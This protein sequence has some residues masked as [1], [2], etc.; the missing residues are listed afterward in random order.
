MFVYGANGE[1]DGPA[2]LTNKEF[3]KK[4]ANQYTALLSSYTAEGQ[5]YRVD[6]RL[7]PDGTLGEICLSEAGAREYYA[8]RARDWE[9]QMLIKARVS[10]GES[11]PGAA[12]LEFV[13][14][15]IYQSS[16]DFS[17][18]G[19]W[20]GTSFARGPGGY[21]GVLAIV[22]IPVAFSSRRWRLPAVGFALGGLLG[23]VLNLDWLTLLV[24]TFRVSQAIE[25]I[26]NIAQ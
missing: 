8:T 10:A 5:C 9:K 22:L 17:A 14:P 2:V 20:W 18:V 6:L 16:L 23:W 24:G 12:L 13:E 3:Y 15:L 19:P 4:V 7:R 26:A 11:E 25:R 1:T 21:V